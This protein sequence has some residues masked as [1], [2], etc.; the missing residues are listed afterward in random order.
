MNSSEYKDTIKDLTSSFVLLEK[1]FFNAVEGR[2]EIKFKKG[3]FVKYSRRRRGQISARVRYGKVAISPKLDTI[4]DLSEKEVVEY[5]AK[6]WDSFYDYALRTSL[7]IAGNR[8]YE[9]YLEYW[10]CDKYTDKG[11]WDTL[12]EAKDATGVS[13]LGEFGCYSAYK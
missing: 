4:K 10:V 12:E 6:Y 9:E 13:D 3:R 11:S 8:S 1:V 5:I 7:N 2:Y